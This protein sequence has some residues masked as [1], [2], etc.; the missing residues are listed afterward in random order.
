MSIGVD[1]NEIPNYRAGAAAEGD[2]EG[3]I[4]G[5]DPALAEELASVSATGPSLLTLVNRGLRFGMEPLAA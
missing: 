3:S 5:I 4:S 1:V 2:E